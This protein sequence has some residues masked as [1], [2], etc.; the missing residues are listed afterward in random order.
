MICPKGKSSLTGIKD[1]FST[2]VM[3]SSGKSMLSYR[4]FR[5]QATDWSKISERALNGFAG[6]LFIHPLASAASFS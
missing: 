5:G 4:N 6:G 1:R 3:P 2:I